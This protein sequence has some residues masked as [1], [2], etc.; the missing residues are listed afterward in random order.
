M[1]FDD[2]L[3]FVVGNGPSLK[4]GI[5]DSLPEGRWVGMNAA[6]KYWDQTGQYPLIYACLDPVVVVQHSDAIKRMLQ[7]GKIRD[8]FL[9]EQ[10]LTVLPELGTHSRVFL[11]H[12][13]IE[14]KGSLPV[15]RLSRYKQTTGVLATRFCIERGFRNLCLLGIDCNYVERLDEA[16]S[17]EGYELVITDSVRRNPNYFFDSY[18][19]KDE[20]YQ[21]PN[22][23][24]HSGNLHLQSF[25][26]LRN[27]IRNNDVPVRIAVGSRE[28]LLSR[29]GIFP[30]LDVTALLGKRRLEAIAVPLTPGEVDLFLKGLEYWIDPKLQPSF[31]RVEGVV[32][33]VFLSCGEEPALRRKIEEAVARL[34]WLSTWFS[35]LRL[36]FL[37]LSPDVDYYIKGTSLNVFCNKSGPNLFWL[38]VMAACRR[39]CFTFQME[40]D[41][42]PVRM[43]WLDALERA[44]QTAPVGAWVIGAQYFGPTIISA[45]NA[46]HINGNALYATGDRDFQDYLDG[47]FKKFIFWSVENISNNIAYDTA[48]S[49]G[50]I[51]YADLLSAKGIDLRKYAWRYV[52]N[53]VV[54]NVSGQVETDGAAG[55]DLVSE[56]MTDSAAFLFHGRP[57]LRILSEC[58]DKL[59]S[60]YANDIEAV[61]EIRIHSAHSRT[62]FVAVKNK[63]F[64]LAAV[65]LIGERKLWPEK[66][67]V[68]FGATADK[69][70]GG[71]FC[72]SFRLPASLVL[73]KAALAGPDVGGQKDITA[74]VET[75]VDG[76]VEIKFG[77][78]T[79]RPARQEIGI[80][81]SLQ[82]A[83]K[84]KD[85]VVHISKLRLLNFSGD[86][87]PLKPSIVPRTPHM[88]E[89]EQDWIQWISM[90]Q[91]KVD[92]KFSFIRCRQ[93]K[94][95]PVLKEIQA[96]AGLELSAGVMGLS[97]ISAPRARFRFGTRARL[98]GESEVCI[99]VAV[100]AEEDCD[101]LI[102]G[103][104]FGFFAVTSQKSVA[105]GITTHISVEFRLRASKGLD[106]FL[107]IEVQP[108]K[109][110][111]HD[112][113]VKVEAI[114]ILRTPDFLEIPATQE[115]SRFISINPDAESF[116]G[117][118]LNYE[119]RLGRAIRARGMEHVIAGPV[120]GEAAIYSAHP[121]LVP[122][123][124]VRS[125]ILYART[126]GGEVPKLADFEAELDR[127][128]AGLDH[129]R[130]SILFMY[131]GSLEVA[132]VFAGLVGKYPACTF[133]ISLYYLSWLDLSAPDL[134]TYWKPRLMA[135]AQHPQLRI[136]VPSQELAETL[137]ADFGVDPEVLPHPSTSFHDEEV[138]S[139]AARTA[140]VQVA[141]G[142]TVVFPGNQRGGKGY[143][144]TR[145]AIIAL[146]AA[147]VP[148]LKLRVRCP[149]DDSLDM[150]RRDFFA[151]IRDRVDVLD[152]YLDEA[153][154]RALLQSAD[155]VVL[156]YT[157]DRFANRT[158]GLLIDSLLL[159]IPCVVI[160]QTWLERMA[161][162]Y[163][164]GIATDQDGHA[165]ARSILDALPRLKTLNA[166]ALAGRDLYFV[167]NSWQAL[168]DYLVNPPTCTTTPAAAPKIDVK[169]AAQDASLPKVAPRRLLIIG[170]GPSTRLLAEAGFERLP[171]D[172]D[173]W[174][175]TAAYRYFENIGWWPTYYALADRK[176]VFH[177]RQNFARLLD[178]P[179]VTTRKFFLSWKV[180]DNP[181]MELIP[182]SSTGSFSLKK[183]LELGYREIYLIGMEGAYVE[184]ILESHA[185]SPEEITAHGF[186]LLKLSPAESKLRIIEQ[187]PTHNP[188]YFFPGYQQA[189]DVYSLPQAHTHQANWDGLKAMV[190]QTG[191][192]VINLSRISKIEAFERGDIRDV[193][194]YL[195]ADCWNDLR[196]PF[197]D[198]AQHAKSV[199]AVK[200]GGGL[201]PQSDAVWRCPTGKQAKAVWRAIFNHVGV[202]EGRT[203]AAG[204][205]IMANRDLRLGIT[206]G[207]EGE[208][209]FEGTGRFFNLKAGKQMTVHL[210]TD[211]RKRHGKLKLQVSQIE[212]AADQ[213]FDL[214]IQ[215]V[216]LTESVDSVAARHEAKELTAR[217]AAFAFSEGNNS[218]AL[219]I[220]LWLARQSRSA[221]YA[222]DIARVAER[223]GISPDLH[224]VQRLIG[225][226]GTIAPLASERPAESISSATVEGDFLDSLGHAVMEIGENR[227]QA[228]SLFLTACAASLLLHPQTTVPRL[229]EGRPLALALVDAQ[230]AVSEAAPARVHFLKV[231][232]HARRKHAVS[233]S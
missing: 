69:A 229:A 215:H 116:F 107:T 36:T 184:E 37:N 82:R 104:A 163:D 57:A 126:P 22:P 119:A 153:A 111:N 103:K 25:V 196:D 128:L 39:Y 40:A 43:G 110:T 1:S 146:L 137:R 7:D 157:P 191:A 138:R 46:F 122:V 131:C 151:S 117:H 105:A 213:E 160:R 179:K 67:E 30:D 28:S 17:T 58:C 10:I 53:P 203:L 16:R 178:D 68:F 63:G 227:S 217:Q 171:D 135:M 214:T 180:S 5:L 41:C 231:L 3:F 60:F 186:G 94:S 159:G 61:S 221:A 149:P 228:A 156:P 204:M 199:H 29:F 52:A 32:L 55:I 136:I 232:S 11:R 109:K 62:K 54:R 21:V 51:R 50:M 170:N 201:I 12:H 190:E 78:D 97:A 150:V 88:V 129:A 198:R 65:E 222:E 27:D 77:A 20:K 230:K 92:Q 24:V 188:N 85:G 158:S 154:F 167:A 123:F 34:P 26:A 206:F 168:A 164:F 99:S 207:R 80:H 87:A 76:H 115:F 72:F 15:S 141:G 197:S 89:L 38:M 93:P 127:Y 108:T 14:Q 98:E 177:H 59:H 205:R 125:N 226:L 219:A 202:T 181:R 47:E 4:A 210:A 66:L 166:A 56:V 64:G 174:G 70:V 42:V 142:I 102:S 19:E 193:F 9:H 134:R 144:L 175:T 33:H 148:G 165:M 233:I 96:E 121:E 223:I 147:D 101:V 74:F 44:V 182:H 195:P 140:A 6:Y 211:F 209:D 194:P 189:G 31:N 161:N 212:C 8:F 139:M 130:P 143:E 224:D 79:I 118:F 112:F 145:D 2:D 18:Q 73:S 23:E 155:L 124:S 71:T 220:W 152:S 45:T 95:M 83:S 176:V 49:Q 185:L 120:D 113:L 106:F 208:T 86:M 216:W 162:T 48:F 114:E 90:N 75:G 187:T 84:I 218:F 183:A 133:A 225:V 91:Q 81:L 13:F 35:E 200:V 192:R 172:M 100:N 132:E 173:S 169:A